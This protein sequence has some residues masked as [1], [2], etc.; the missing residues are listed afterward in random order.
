MHWCLKDKP[1]SGVSSLS[2]S[3]LIRSPFLIQ[4][5]HSSASSDYCKQE[6]ALNNRNILWEPWRMEVWCQHDHLKALDNSS[7]I[8]KPPKPLCSS[9]PLSPPHLMCGSQ[10]QVPPVCHRTI[11]QDQ[12][13]RVTITYQN[14]QF[15]FI[16]MF[17]KGSRKNLTSE[18]LISWK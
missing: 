11:I 13:F 1:M 16:Q 3:E 10:C 7:T 17:P 4:G 14:K 5:V 2:S 6:V 12:D 9:L 15:F 18:Q 8:L